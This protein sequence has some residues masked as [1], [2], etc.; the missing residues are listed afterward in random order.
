[1]ILLKTQDIETINKYSQLTIIQLRWKNLYNLLITSN[2]NFL[3]EIN[4]YLKIYEFTRSSLL[5][6]FDT[7]PNKFDPRI[8]EKLKQ[9]RDNESLLHDWLFG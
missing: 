3:D 9:F 6:S 8:K 5:D 1:M 2:K 7:D 4:K